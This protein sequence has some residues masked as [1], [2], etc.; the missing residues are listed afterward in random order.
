MKVRHIWDY[1]LA[2]DPTL[3]F[4]N[5]ESDIWTRQLVLWVNNAIDFRVILERNQN[6]YAY[7]PTEVIF[8]ISIIPIAACG[9]LLNLFK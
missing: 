1:T 7:I 2:L 6:K 3:P 9:D 8:S 5:N 4:Q